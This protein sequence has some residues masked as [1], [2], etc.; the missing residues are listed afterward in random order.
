M[1][2]SVIIDQLYSFSTTSLIITSLTSILTII[3][4][5]NVTNQ[6][7]FKDRNTPP[8]VFHIFPVLGSVISYGMDPYQFFEDCRRK[9][10][11]VFTFVLLN[12]K[13]T[14]ALGPEGNTL[15]L[16]GK[17][18]E[19]NAEEAYTHFTTPVFGKDVVYDVPNS[20]L[21]QQKKFI[22]AGLTTEKFKKYVGIIVRETTSYLEDH[23]FCSPN[24]KSVTKDVHDITSEITI[25]TAA[26]TL[27][28]KEVREGL[29]KSFAKLYHDLDGGFTPLNF[30]FPNLPLPSYRRR[31]KAQVSMTNFYLNILKKRRA[32]NRQDEF[33]D[34]LDVLQGQHYK[35]GRAL[36]D[37]EIAHIMIAV[38][39]AGQHTSAATGAWLLTHLAHCPDLVDRL[40]R[41][42]AEVFG[43]GDGS[44]ELEDLDYDRLQTPL[45]NSCIK[46][47]LRLHPPIHSILRKVKSP[48]LVPKTLSSIDKNNQYII[49]SSHYVLAAPGVSQID[50]SVW[51]HPKEFRP[52]RWLSN[53][54]KDKQEQEEEMVDYGF[55][56]ISSGANSPYLPFGAG[57]H[58]CIGEQFAYIQ[59]AAVAVAVIRNCDLELVRKEFPLPDYTTMLVGPRKPT[60]VKFTRRN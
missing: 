2:S 5:L 31:D 42:Q 27:Q 34:M 55:G 50:P 25:C 30:V 43:K 3:V 33:N 13:V 54:K 23:L 49:P 21:M 48:I 60:T 41:E 44:G 36:S 7:L 15:V 59:L 26:A 6:L 8:L 22:K 51:D 35:D 45:L 38:L 57:R 14:V 12:K 19:V 53:F 46:E 40:R 1:S 16:N 10:G 32:E 20:I 4:I 58:R 52:E 39:M 17:L 47:V 24:V 37:R 18:S 9:H 29:D 28:G 11:N 56:A